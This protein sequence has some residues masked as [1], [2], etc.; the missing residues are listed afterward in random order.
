MLF[1][2]QKQNKIKT[3]MKKTITL[4]CAALCTVML[5][6]QTTPTKL[7]LTVGD[8]YAL[9]EES[10]MTSS[11]EV[12]GQEMKSTVNLTATVH[13]EVLAF[14]KGVYKLQVNNQGTKGTVG[15]AMFSLDIDTKAGTGFDQVGGEMPEFL[16]QMA[17]LQYVLYVKEDGTIEKTEGLDNLK[18][19]SDEEAGMVSM[20][21]MSSM[22][23][24]EDPAA[25]MKK[26]IGFG[27]NKAAGATWALE[28][29]KDKNI[30][31]NNYTVKEITADASTIYN[32]FTGTNEM[33]MN[34]MNTSASVKG[35]TDGS[36]SI[37]I[38]AT[39]GLV[40]KIETNSNSKNA[41]TVRGMEI[42]ST[43]S[44][45]VITTFTKM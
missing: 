24:N 12:N 13:V 44:A 5:Y 30:T 34:M 29:G 45:T 27:F 22:L 25:G 2:L 35:S 43:G 39:T 31:K 26:I 1:A 28:T 40:T 14:D 9:V 7:T 36:S 20:L 21:G 41:V 19:A 6:A 32:V 23:E 10:A 16:K 8:K 42:P 4:L 18:K 37:T 15:S 33:E 3:T 38:S 17:N 11:A